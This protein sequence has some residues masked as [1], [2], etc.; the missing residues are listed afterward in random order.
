MHGKFV[1]SGIL[2]GLLLASLP[3]SVRAQASRYIAPHGKDSGRD[4]SDPS[5]PC[6]TIRHALELAET[7]DTLILSPGTYTESGLSIGKELTI[8]G[9]HPDKTIVQGASRPEEAGDRVFEILKDTIVV[10]E[11]LTIRHGTAAGRGGGLLNRGDL[12]LSQVRVLGNSTGNA[13]G[14]SG[15]GLYNDFHSTLTMSD[16]LIAGNYT[17]LSLDD[18]GSGG[19]GLYN[20]IG[21]LV[22]LV[23]CTIRNNWTGAQETGFGGEGGGIANLG[24]LV[25][26]R[27]TITENRT[28]FGGE[29]GGIWSGVNSSSFT[30][31]NSLVHGNFTSGGGHGGGIY[32]WR[33]GTLVNSTIS[34][35]RT[36]SRSGEHGSTIARASDG[37]GIYVPRGGVL[38]VAHCTIAD[39]TSE[40]GRGGGIYSAEPVFDVGGTILMEDSVVAGNH[41]LAREESADCFGPVTS[42]GYNLIK[43]PRGC[44]LRGDT[45]TLLSGVDPLL[46][47]LRNN[48]GPTKTHALLPSSPA[49]DAGDP[50]PAILPETDQRG[51]P[52]VG[53]GRIDMG[54]Y[55]MGPDRFSAYNDLSWRQ[56]QTDRNITRYTTENGIGSP[57]EGSRG[58]LI[59]FR[60]GLPVLGTLSVT[61]GTWDGAIHPRQGRLSDRGTDAHTIFNGKVNT[62]G[63]VGYGEEN[64]VLTFTSL[65]PHLQYEVSLFANR[66]REDYKDRVTTT[67]LVGAAHL[68]NH[69]SAGADFAGLNDES[70]SIVNGYNKEQGYVARFRNIDP[71]ADGSFA[72]HVSAG[73]APEQ[74]NT[75]YASAVCLKASARERSGYVTE[76]GLSN[77]PGGPQDVTTYLKDETAHLR[78]KDVDLDPNEVPQAS[79]EARLRQNGQTVHKVLSYDAEQSAFLGAL[80]L[81]PFE[82][83]DIQVSITGTVTTKSILIRHSELL[84]LNDE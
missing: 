57:P 31:I 66:N 23:R 1:L 6:L 5:A 83:G 39:N 76:I 8:Q 42:G 38:T 29:G 67:E 62:T 32:A 41:V 58:S 45:L 28:R 14:T 74:A 33:T 35:N 54:A 50:N 11:G 46:S 21:G 78:I 49:I 81:S 65:D 20:N 77:E 70:V 60:S 36:G 73:G 24:T 55:E 53:Q 56:G 84:I 37:G 51:N 2:S 22:T 61:G 63:V 80:D 82:P 9:N 72:L 34:G 71:G 48:G 25:V 69:S 30:L 68:E 4:C 16:C 75:Y 18:F 7:G 3:V 64:L 44:T 15:G 40:D 26:D 59:D 17:G 27:C 52:R 79:V 43:D 10:I 47:L 13:F 19:G 12:T